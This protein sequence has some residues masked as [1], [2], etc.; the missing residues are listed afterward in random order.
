MLSGE[1]GWSPLL[2]FALTFIGIIPLAGLLGSCTEELAFWTGPTIGGLVNASLG[3]APE[4]IIS[5]IA[6]RQGL[7]R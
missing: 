3:N 7:L 4:L 2:T 5:I 6:M 1:L